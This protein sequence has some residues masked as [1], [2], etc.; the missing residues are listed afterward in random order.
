MYAPPNQFIAENRII[1]ASIGWIRG[2]EFGGRKNNSVDDSAIVHLWARQLSTI[3]ATFQFRVAN[4]AFN[5][6]NH[7]LNMS[8]VIHDLDCATY[9]IGKRLYSLKHIG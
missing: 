5:S 4:M 6:C 1:P 8:E 2:V 7:L 3:N 9:S